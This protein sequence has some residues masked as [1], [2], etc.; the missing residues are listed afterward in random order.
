M[1]IP[2]AAARLTSPASKL[3]NS[4]RLGVN[5]A[6]DINDQCGI[7]GR[8]QVMSQLPIIARALCGD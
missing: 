6:G 2:A 5:I 7:D 8:R 4:K 3:L 1:R